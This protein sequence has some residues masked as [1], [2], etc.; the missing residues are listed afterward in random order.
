MMLSM[1]CLRAKE[2]C[3]LR[4][5][6]PNLGENENQIKNSF[7]LANELNLKLF[8]AYQKRF[9]KNFCNII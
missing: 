5:C 4:K 6:T 2:T 9:D 8:I 7:K 3:F 1:K